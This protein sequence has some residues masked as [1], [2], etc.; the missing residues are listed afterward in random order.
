MRKALPASLAAVGVIALVAAPVLKY[1]V[2]PSQ[3]QLPSDT[4]TIRNYAG[5]FDTL[6][7]ADALTGGGGP[8]LLTGVPASVEKHVTVEAT[9]GDVALLRDAN[10]VKAAD[11]VV[12]SST[13]DYS[14][15]RKTLAGTAP[16]GL[17]GNNIVQPKGQTVTWPIDTE[18][19]DYVYWVQDTGQ[20]VPAV[21]EGSERKGGLD[22]YVFTANAPAAPI[23]DE[24]VLASF[25]A[26][27]PKAT[28]TALAGQLG[29][30]DAET[31]ALGQL[32]AALPDEVPLSYTYAGT[33]KV[34]V[35]PETGL[36]IASERDETR[37]VNIA[38]TAAT[39]S[40]PL[41]PV[42]KLNFTS[43]DAS[44]TAAASD[45]N[46]AVDRK[47]L[48][49]TT[50]PIVLLVLGLGLLGAAAVLVRQGRGRTGSSN[51]GN[52]DSAP[53]QPSESVTGR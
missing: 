12:A 20:G 52:V 35:E 46:D 51:G 5:T 3:S 27:L 50:L 17:E 49:G 53:T 23:V 25:P 14:V 45:A 19:K 30:A 34:F 48:Y 36:V 26:T 29:L 39:P 33:T 2:V 22:T 13:V 31:A 16:D 44:I 21:Y 24:N 6:L 32:L 42:W 40:V 11:K 37:V 10:V 43:T 18:R 7:N 1:G 38:A 47:Q 4:D 15:D 8:A 9:S 41:T 28:L